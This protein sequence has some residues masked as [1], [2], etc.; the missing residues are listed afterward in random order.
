MITWAVCHWG[1]W[2]APGW[3]RTYIERMASM[4]ERWSPRPYR[5]VAF[6]DDSDVC[7]PGVDCRRLRAP[8]WKGRFPKFFVYQPEARLTGRVILLD[9]DNVIVGPLDDFAAYRGPLA[10]KGQWDHWLRGI[11]TPDGDIISFEADGSVANRLYALTKENPRRVAARF[12]GQERRLMATATKSD[13][14]QRVCPGQLVS[15]KHE[16][17]GRT[18]KLPKQARIVTFHGK[19]RQHEVDEPWIA[20]NWR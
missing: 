9:L 6:V 2:P 16:M 17:R 20:E 15:W 13:V 19:P 12:R 7:P 1:D 8:T 11:C 14:W 18:T 4:L 5:F 3:G 10:T